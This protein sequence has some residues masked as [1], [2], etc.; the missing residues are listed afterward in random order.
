M[1]AETAHLGL[2][3]AKDKVYAVGGKKYHRSLRNAA[4][5]DTASMTWRPVGAL[6]AARGCHGIAVMDSVVYVAGGFD[7]RG[8][9]LASM[10]RYDLAENRW[11]PAAAM[12]QGR[13][14]FGMA[15]LKESIYAVGGSSGGV[16]SSALMEKYYPA[17][18]KWSPVQAT[19]RQPRADFGLAALDGCL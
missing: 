15:T 6:T 14:K 5:F 13:A 17:L 4:V 9:V 12:S 19:L 18:D 10:E 11:R 7:E 3:F 1:N 16:L 2:A 8:Y